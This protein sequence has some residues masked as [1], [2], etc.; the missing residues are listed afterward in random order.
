MPYFNRSVGSVNTLISVFLPDSTVTTGAGLANIVASTVRLTWWRDNQATVSSWTLTTGT[1]GTWA[2]S[3]MVQVG[4]TSSLGMY[5]FSLPDGMFASGTNAAAFIMSSTA[6]FAPV[7]LVF[8]LSTAIVGVS[9]VTTPVT[10]SSVTAGV[11]V[12]SIHGS[13]AVTSAAGVFGPLAVSSLT[14]PVTASSVTAA[15]NVSSIYGSNAVTSAAGVWGPLAV[16]S[17]TTPVTASSVTRAVDVTS[18]IGSALVTSA[19][20]VLGPLAVSSLTTPVTVSAGSVR[21][22]SAS[23]P[24]GVS[25]L[26][27]SAL[28]NF[29]DTGA[30]F[31]ST[32]VVSSVVFEIASNAT[33]VL[34]GDVGVSSIST[35]VTVSSVT[36]KAGYGVSSISTPVA[37][38]SGSLGVSSLTAAAN[39][40][41]ADKLLGRNVAGGSDGGRI[42]SEALYV[43][44]NKVDAGAGIVYATDD[45]TSSWAFTVSTTPGDPI[46]SIDPA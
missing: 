18:F 26:S 7:P 42:V 36:D 27:A 30:A 9:S 1:L 35:P 37:A 38:S 10:A 41:I 6:T 11:N 15:V 14:T 46:V 13:A 45:V 25:S 12:T 20:G 2:A 23:I 8:D 22:T 43:L 3:T 19:A 21:V 40:S 44:R 17:L 33:A 4:S 28:R 32:A 31:Y 5:Q 24:F 29:F 34:S 16:S 39:A